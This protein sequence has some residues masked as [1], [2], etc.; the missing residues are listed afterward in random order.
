MKT[1]YCIKHPQTDSIVYIGVTSDLST[2]QIAHNSTRASDL[3]KDFKK[4]HGKIIL[5]PIE[6]CDNDI[7]IERETYWI[8]KLVKEGVK[9]LN[10]AKTENISKVSGHVSKPR[11]WS[12]EMSKLEIGSSFECHEEFYTSMRGLRN[13]FR[14]KGF[15]FQFKLGKGILTVRRTR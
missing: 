9:L 8:H 5:H 4:E 1:V 12:S 2:R 7:S 13:K 15:D 11:Y 3:I 14:K 6:E 10:Y